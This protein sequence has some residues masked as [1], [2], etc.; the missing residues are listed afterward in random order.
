MVDEFAI[1]IF[2]DARHAEDVPTVIYVEKDV[3]IKVLIIFAIAVTADNY[4]CRINCKVCFELWLSEYLAG[5][6]RLFFVEL[7]ED[8][9]EWSFLLSF[10][11]VV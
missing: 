7:F 1:N 3:S 11:F 10:S 9:A 6:I 8:F 2:V 4:F 5:F